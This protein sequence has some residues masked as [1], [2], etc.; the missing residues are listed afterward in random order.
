VKLKDAKV[1]STKTVTEHWS[2]CDKHNYTNNYKISSSKVAEVKLFLREK[3]RQII[4]T[5]HKN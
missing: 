3:Q 1:Y 4:I 2:V 5:K